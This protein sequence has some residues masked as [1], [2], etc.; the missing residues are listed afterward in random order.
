M[1]PDVFA[2]IH[3]GNGSGS[4][5]RRSQNRMGEPDEDERVLLERRRDS[6][7]TKNDARGHDW[8]NCESTGH[9]KHRDVSSWHRH[10]ADGDEVRTPGSCSSYG[11]KMCGKRSPPRSRSQLNIQR[12]QEL[13]Q[14]FST[15]RI[16]VPRV[17]AAHNR[18]QD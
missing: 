4:R 9:E 8:R 18:G 2:R 13:M 1:V 17:R 12:H 16:C 14:I 5:R 11:T 3:E 15:T 10:G 7:R 6:G